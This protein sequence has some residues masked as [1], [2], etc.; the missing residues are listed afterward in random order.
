MWSHVRG[1]YRRLLAL[2][3]QTFQERFGESMV[4]TFNDLYKERERRHGL[5]GLVLWIFV[6]TGIGVVYEHTSQISPGDIMKNILSNPKSAAMMSFI[7]CLPLALPYIIFMFDIEPLTGLANR[8]LTTDGQQINNLGRVL[9]F[10][11]L[12]IL[13][14]AFIINLTP[15]GNQKKRLYA[16]NLVLGIAL[17]LLITFTWG[18]LLLEQTQCLRGIYC[19]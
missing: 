14:V 1:L 7:L 10:G 18:G 5:F 3:P 9:L 6:E 17:L 19:D 12:L 11:G 8:L 13:P 4:Q 2:Y 15:W 16:F